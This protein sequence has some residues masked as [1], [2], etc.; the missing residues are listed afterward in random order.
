MPDAVYIPE[1]TSDIQNA[2][3]LVADVF[4]DPHDCLTSERS[5][6]IP[7]FSKDAITLGVQIRVKSLPIDGAEMDQHEVQDEVSCSRFAF[8]NRDTTF[9][10]VDQQVPD[11]ELLVSYMSH[12][13]RSGRSLTFFQFK[14]QTFCSLVQSG[15]LSS[16]RILNSVMRYV[17]SDEIRELCLICNKTR[18]IT[19]SC[20]LPTSIPSHPMDFSLFAHNFTLYSG[21]FRSSKTVWSRSSSDVLIKLEPE[22]VRCEIVVSVGAAM[23]RD[24][25]ELVKARTFSGARATVAAVPTEQGQERTS[26]LRFS[27]VRS[28]SVSV[29]SVPLSGGTNITLRTASSMC[30]DDRQRGGNT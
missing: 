6:L 26:G 28:A 4:Q 12:D 7:L 27:P 5:A 9:I 15:S 22:E 18:S 10:S 25:C 1:V 13:V 24:I 21:D 2:Y 23:V 17:F 16:S 8:D 30:M 14:A 20:T 19:C 3:A 29:P 11:R